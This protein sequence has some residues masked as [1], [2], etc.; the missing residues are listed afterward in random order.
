MLF[1]SSLLADG[2]LVV[3]KLGVSLGFVDFFKGVY[4]GINKDVDEVILV[5]VDEDSDEVILVDVDEDFNEEILIDVDEVI[6]LDVDEGFDEVILI[7]CDEGFDEV[8]LIDFDEDVDEVI[9]LD[10]DLL[11]TFGDIKVECTLFLLS[12]FD[13]VFAGL[14]SGSTEVSFF[15]D[16]AAGVFGCAVDVN[17]FFVKGFDIG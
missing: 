2:L 3:D 12:K 10:V 1:L 6:F 16:S 11:F 8:I 13:S 7:D 4:K 9:L 5:D 14:Y 17:S 15:L